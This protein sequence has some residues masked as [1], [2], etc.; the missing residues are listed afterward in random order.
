MNLPVFLSL[1]KPYTEEQK[2][3]RDNMIKYMKNHGFEPR[4]V[5]ATNYFLNEPLSGCRMVLLE[6]YGL[7]TLAFR[8]YYIQ[9]GAENYPDNQTLLKCDD[10]GRPIKETPIKE[11]YLTSPW[12]QME[13]AMAYQIGLPILIFREEGVMARGLLAKGTSGTYLPVFK[14][15]EFSTFFRK[16]EFQQCFRQWSGRVQSVRE[17]KGT[18]PKLYRDAQ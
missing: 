9:E 17:L 11:E 5:G 2:K 14:A 10:D 13:T 1:S 7:I 8:R 12:C 18:P 15:S 3:F 16:S 6:S 4:T